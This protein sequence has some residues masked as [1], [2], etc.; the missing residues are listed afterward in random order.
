MLSLTPTLLQ[1]P[2]LPETT[3]EV[4]VDKALLIEEND[5]SRG[6]VRLP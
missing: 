4:E 3:T 6:H 2:E 5:R 1:P